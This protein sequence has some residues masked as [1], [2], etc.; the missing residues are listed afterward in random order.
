[1]A[2]L[3]DEERLDQ[4]LEEEYQAGV[5]PLGSTLY[6]IELMRA[7]RAQ[8]RAAIYALWAAIGTAACAVFAAAAVAISL[9]AHGSN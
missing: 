3:S 6:I 2:K 4:I 5:L 7:A 9:F 1:M 8:R